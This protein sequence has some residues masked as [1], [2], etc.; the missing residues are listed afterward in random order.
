MRASPSAHL[1]WSTGQSPPVIAPFDN[2]DKLAIND[3]WNR[4]D[5]EIIDLKVDRD[6]VVAFGIYT[7]SNK[8]LKL[9]A[10]LY[11]LYPKETREI[12]LEIE[13]RGK[14]KEIQKREVNDIGVGGPISRRK[15]G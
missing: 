12:R 4:G 5:N 8:T 7:V 11:P 6:S 2:V 9:T 15:L 14:W 1:R 13:D 3:W 10:Q